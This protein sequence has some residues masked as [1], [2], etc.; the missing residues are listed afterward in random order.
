MGGNSGF[1][2]FGDFFG[3]WLS[4]DFVMLTKQADN[5]VWVTS[6]SIAKKFTV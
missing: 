3:V 4:C 1:R 6:Y 2:W 5:A